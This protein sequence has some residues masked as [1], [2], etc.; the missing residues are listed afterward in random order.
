MVATPEA[1]A[2][3]SPKNGPSQH[4]AHSPLLCPQFTEISHRILCSFHT[5]VEELFA[6]IDRCLA[7]NRSVLQQ[8]EEQC[9]RELTDED[10]R[11]IHMQVGVGQ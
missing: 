10:W 6:E 11:K 8:L 9:G 5:D 1:L 3:S 2:S 4:E 7:I